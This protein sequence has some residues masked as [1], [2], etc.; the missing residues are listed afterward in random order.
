[1]PTSDANLTN[2]AYCQEAT[3]GV[4]AAN[5]DFRTAR[6]TGESIGHGKETIQSAEIRRDRQIVDLV[7]VGSSATGGLNFELS[8]D[9]FKA[10]WE[11]LL[12]GTWVDYNVTA[13][14]G[15]IVAGSTQT[16]TATTPGD[17][18]DVPVGGFVKVSGATADGNNGV[19]RVVG[20]DVTNTILTFAPGS[21]TEAQAGGS[22][23][24]NTRDLR[25][26]TTRRS[27]T[28]EREIENSIGDLI[29]QTYPGCYLGEGSLKV[30]SKQICTGT[31]TVLGKYGETRSVSLN[32]N[33]LAFAEGT[34]TFV[35]NPSNGDTAIIG[36]KTYTFQTTLTNVNG[37]V[38]IGSDAEESLDNLIAAINLGAGSGTAYAAAMTLHPTVEAAAG[39]GDTMDL[40]AKTAGTAGNLIG[41]TETFT[42]AGNVF[43][44]TTLTG[45]VAHEYLAAEDGDVLNGTS[46]MG[47]ILGSAGAYAEKLKMVSFSINNMLRGKDALA[48]LGNFEVGL[49]TLEVKGQISAYFADN[50][51]YAALIA[52]DDNALAFT[53]TDSAGNTRCFT[54]PRIKWGA[55]NPN[56]EAI[57]TD[58]ML[59]IDFTAIR[60]ALT[61]VTCIVNDLDA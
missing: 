1:M 15:D 27:F 32:T 61:G 2:L 47:T 12:C 22:I 26:G 24:F 25:N 3:Y 21:F 42:N 36:G 38:Q 9:A 39:S 4:L 8:H 46:N 41:T 7:E 20:K 30:E 48:E 23:D 51:L 14:G 33:E 43:G 59:N 50:T 55:G 40:T 52:H 10:F 54:F 44:A 5:P 17:V 18:A 60:D 28:F 35:A 13:V 56:A 45:G 58:V 6:I 53:L 29:Y 57:N 19:K 34:L 11:A 31:F 49:G 16:F 37:N